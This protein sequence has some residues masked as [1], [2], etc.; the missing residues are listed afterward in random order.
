MA[1]SSPPP[2][3]SI[4]LEGMDSHHRPAQQSSL[5]GRSPQ[6]DKSR[7]EVRDQP[8]SRV[9][10]GNLQPV[11]TLGVLKLPGRSCPDGVRHGLCQTMSFDAAV[12][13]QMSNS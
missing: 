8:G 9:D 10:N 13:R 2:S 12:E 7:V 1:G 3:K 11:G 6:N 5:R 4:L